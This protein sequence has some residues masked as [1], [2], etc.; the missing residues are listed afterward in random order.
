[1]PYVTAGY[2]T[3]L[4]FTGMSRLAR[5]QGQSIP[6]HTCRSPAF[7]GLLPNGTVLDIWRAS[8]GVYY[9]LYCF[10]QK[11]KNDGASIAAPSVLSPLGGLKK[12][13][14]YAREKWYSI[15][16]YDGNYAAWLAISRGIME[17]RT[18]WRID[19]DCHKCRGNLTSIGVRC[20]CLV[21][22]F[23]YLV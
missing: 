3:R 1:M 9:H 4:K 19:A 7:S 16:N 2:S 12:K 10:S 8:L 15:A 20:E 21:P 6:T 17:I 11:K 22:H 14:N 5:L 13:K 18:N 23:A